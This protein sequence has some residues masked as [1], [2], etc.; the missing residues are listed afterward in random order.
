MP[1]RYVYIVCKNKAEARKIALALLEK[2]WIGCANIYPIEAL[3]NWKGKLTKAKEAVLI[4]K[5][6]SKNVKKTMALAK[7]LHSY[8]EPCIT[9]IPILAADK[10]YLNWMKSEIK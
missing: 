5:T 2:K 4:A 3:F 8:E 6:L 10:D 7:K 1:M 9:V